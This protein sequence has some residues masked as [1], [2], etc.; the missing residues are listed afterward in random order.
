MRSRLLK[1]GRLLTESIVQAEYSNSL[2]SAAFLRSG[3]V[4]RLSENASSHA[5][6]H[7]QKPSDHISSFV[8]NRP[9]LSAT[10]Q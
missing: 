9:T 1:T 8:L 10:S 6:D 4:A 7:N 5:Q 2:C 3:M